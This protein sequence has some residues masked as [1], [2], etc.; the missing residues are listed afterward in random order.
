[1]G[2]PVATMHDNTAVLE[3]STKCIANFNATAFESSID[4][5]ADQHDTAYQTVAVIA[6]LVGTIMLFAGYSLFYF[7]LA[8]AGL[9]LG[10]SVAFFLLCGTT[11]QIIVASIGGAVAGILLGSIVTKL[12][13]LG[14]L[15]IGVAGGLIAALYTNGFVMNHLYDQ[16]SALHQ[17]W[18]PYVYATLLALIGIWLAFKLERIVIVCATA[19]GGA[20]ALGWGA[21]RLIYGSDHADL[22]PLYLFNGQGCDE[23]FC[24]FAL[25]A[26]VCL[27]LVGAYVQF[28]GTCHKQ[29]RFSKRDNGPK[30]VVVLNQNDHTVLLIQGN[31]VKGEGLHL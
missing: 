9:I 12:E 24:K 8:T 17:S 15:A 4:Q 5:F 7:T 23:K 28:R 18:M 22:G 19:F 20:Y 3:W 21:I 10:G 6:I 29:S 27:A 2:E 26:V 11:H 16:F 1:M 25:A 31:Q 13:K 30:D 14:V